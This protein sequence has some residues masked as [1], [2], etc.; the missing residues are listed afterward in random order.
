MKTK[1]KTLYKVHSS[2]NFKKDL[3]KIVKQ[4]KN[5]QKLE[6]IVNKLANKGELEP[7]YRNHSLVDNKYYKGCKECHIEPDWLL[8]YKYKENELILLLIKTGSH[9]GVLNK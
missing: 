1:Q 5:I 4:G 3:K 7:K 9:S 6:N 2:T 8:V